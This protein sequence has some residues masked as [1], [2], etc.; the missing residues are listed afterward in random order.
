MPNTTLQDILGG[1][2]AAFRSKRRLPKHVLHAAQ[3]MMACRTRVLGG[4]VQRCPNGHVQ[5]AW[6]NSCHHRCCPQCNWVRLENWLDRQKSR[7]IDCPHFHVVFTAPDELHSLWRYNW[8]LMADL[9]FTS[10]RD[11]LFK[12]LADRK[13]LGGTPGLIAALHTWGQTLMLHPHLHCLVTAGGLSPDGKWRKVVRK[14]LLPRKV[15]MIIFRGKYL[16]AIRRVLDRGE[17]VL[18][19]DTTPARV[20]SLLNKLG[21]ATWNVKILE[22]YDHGKGVLCYLARYVR[23]GPMSNRRLMGCRDGQVRFR[24]KDN[25]HLDRRRRSKQKTISLPVDQFL[26]RLLQHVPRPGMHMVRSSGLYANS[27]K[28]Q[29]EVARQQQGQGPVELPETLAWYDLLDRLERGGSKRCPVCGA[30]LVRGGEIPPCRGPPGECR[31]S[32]SE[33]AR[34]ALAS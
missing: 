29:L 6:Y 24:Y 12:L 26:A 17:L 15:L 21:R 8:K 34:T 14:C 31:N 1:H 18:P 9:L 23:G 32:S 4:H 28:L 7:V 27:Q 33:P 2:F 11:T 16:A 10:V 13:Y 3:Q 20:R 19:P 25:R 30:V 5:R 22:K